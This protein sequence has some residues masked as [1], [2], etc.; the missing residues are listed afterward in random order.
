[1]GEADHP[2]PLGTHGLAGGG[3]VC[4]P[5]VGQHF[6]RASGWDLGPWEETTALRLGG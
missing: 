6:T 1:M 3:R 4:G 2:N 5:V